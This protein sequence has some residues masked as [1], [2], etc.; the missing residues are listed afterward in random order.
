MMDLLN[1]ILGL[2][3]MAFG[4]EG[5]QFGFA[6]PLPLWAWAIGVLLA[7]GLAWWSYSR[8]TGG[9]ASRA[10]LAGLRAAVLLAI[11]FLIAGPQLIRPNERVE[12]DWV[13]VL[14]DRS[15]S[16]TIADAPGAGSGRVERD[17]QLRDAVSA[18][19]PAFATLAR[20]RTV[21]WL[22]FDSG[23]Y[24]VPLEEEGGEATGVNPGR[25]AGRRT[26]L[27][28]ALE[29]A[30]ARAA[31][32]PIS[33]VVILS[34]G[35]SIDEP[36]RAVLRRL[37]SERIPVFT[38]GL[39]SADPV[40]D[41]ALQQAEAPA[42][43]FVNDTVPVGVEI[44]RLGAGERPLGGRVQLVDKLTGRILDERPIPTDPALWEDHRTR[45][46]LTDRPSVP[47]KFEWSIRIV[48]DAPDLIEQ[49]NRAELAIELVDRPMRVL[50]FD[51]YPRWEY[52]YLKNLLVREHS[53]QSAALLLASSRQYLREG[54]LPL[55]TLPRSPEDWAKFD[56]ILLGDL[57]ATLFSR[58]QL[59]QLRE[60]IAVR[61]AGLLWVGGPGSTPGAWRDSPLAD[62]LPFSLG[63]GQDSSGQSV[64]AWEEPVVM[65]PA[66]AARRLS[67]LELGD[68]PDEGWPAALSDPAT[69]WSQLQYA[70]RIDPAWVK[71]TAEV[72]AYFT[73]VSGAAGLGGPP[74]TPPPQG[75]TP[76]VLSMRYGAGRV[77]YVATDEI[78]RWRYARGE[79]L[80]ERFWLP[81]L[82]L[83]GRESLARASRPAI[84]EITPRR[85]I[86]DQ[87][88]RLSVRILDQSL[89]DAAPAGLTARL[90]RAPGNPDEAAPN[91]DLA[92][93]PEQAQ[94]ER[95]GRSYATTWV[96]GQPG[97]FQAEV[98][99]PAFAG[100][101]LVADIE[102]VLPD[103]ELRRPEADHA[104][105]AR[106]SEQTEGRPLRPA[107]L[108]ELPQLLPKRE[109]HIAGTPDIRTLWDR[110]AVFILLLIL[111]AAEWMGR[112]LVKLP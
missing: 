77:L 79:A 49:N 89:A 6:R 59:E 68:T 112:R 92:L 1:R 46:T 106:L 82:R 107:E 11:L 102:V 109:V 81:L 84:L 18:A 97:K 20:D 58:E 21:Q 44:E 110:P 28:A 101:P 99:D 91:I 111:L 96:P 76:A 66:P 9:R 67:L 62:L 39:G 100:Q 23:V 55:D 57:P 98:A 53:I 43:A 26:A 60:H 103:D 63:S 41:L 17:R 78:W 104:L 25:P 32:R 5:V 95:S 73:P 30:L 87:P 48:P 31:A 94:G 3:G 86:V 90:R 72:L 54:D 19:W 15:A 47:G 52:R 71:P 51:G 70:Q 108:A 24:D 27:G 80:P 10:T 69:G 75:S 35:R 105:L 33:G 38:V 37:Q 88:V 61:G 40:A 65:S 29:Q 36:G 56:V 45:V 7:V 64:R 85:A 14:L 16:M 50:Y 4:Q 8:L 42:L 13:L 74:N 12:R 2:E 93:A 22:G 83:Q 34:D